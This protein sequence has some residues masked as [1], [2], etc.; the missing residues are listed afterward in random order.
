MYY[1]ELG[2]NSIILSTSIFTLSSYSLSVFGVEPRPRFFNSFRVL[3]SIE[4]LSN[5]TCHCLDFPTDCNNSKPAVSDTNLNNLQT[6]FTH[7]D[8][9]LESRSVTSSI[10]LPNFC[11]SDLIRVL[12]EEEHS[13][14]LFVHLSVNSTDFSGRLPLGPQDNLGQGG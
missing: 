3:L 5:Q 6:G 10:L 7:V 1:F 12:L 13:N 9:L 14:N 11:N 8:F 4:L 2:T